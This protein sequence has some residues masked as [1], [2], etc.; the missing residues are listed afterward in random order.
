MYMLLQ[1][2]KLKKQNSKKFKS[3]RH[4]PNFQLKM[5]KLMNRASNV[6]NVNRAKASLTKNSVWRKAIDVYGL[7]KAV[8]IYGP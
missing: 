3:D 5:R 2:V 7:W 6:Y 1:N 8:K 4:I